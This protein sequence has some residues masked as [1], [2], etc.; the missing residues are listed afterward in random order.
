MSHD[1]SAKSPSDRNPLVVPPSERDYRQGELNA[2]VVLVEYGDYQC[3]DCGEIDALI[4]TIQVRFDATFP[5]ENE[6]C[7]VF[8]QFPQPQIHP[9]A[10]K[11]AAAALAA[12]VQGKFW[13]MHE[14]LFTHQQELGNGYLVEYANHLGLDI[15][16]F[17]KELSNR[18]HVDHI[19]EDIESGHHSGATAAPALFINRVRYIGRWSVEQLIVAI[20]TA[21]N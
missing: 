4:K 13:Q 17:L 10:Q 11:A 16:R 19:N 3:P 1:I 8:R 9:Q 14:M 12:G 2:R 7:F 6:L 18:V 5:E 21:S 15:P 20:V